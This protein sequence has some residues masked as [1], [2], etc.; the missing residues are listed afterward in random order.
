MAFPTL[1]TPTSI[2]GLTLCCPIQENRQIIQ[3]LLTGSILNVVL[4]ITKNDD[5]SDG[6]VLSNS[7][8]SME[9][10]SKKIFFP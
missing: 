7:R 4:I 10:N 2:K 1:E 5:E 3:Y 6:C 8:D 9:S